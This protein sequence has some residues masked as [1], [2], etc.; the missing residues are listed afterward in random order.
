MADKRWEN[1]FWEDLDDPEY[2]PAESGRIDWTVQGVRGTRQNPNRETILRSPPQLIGGYHWRIKLYPRGDDTNQLSA[3]VECSPEAWSDCDETEDTS[4]GEDAKMSLETSVEG[5][6]A[7]THAPEQPSR[8]ASPAAEVSAENAD[9]P[10]AKEQA[11]WG[12]AAQFGVV[13]YNPA[14]PR[15]LYAFKEQY[16]FCNGHD[17]FGRKRF[18]GPWD[19]IHTR[20]RGQRQALLRNDTLALSAYIRIVKDPTGSLW[21]SSR[22]EGPGWDNLARTGLRGISSK[23]DGGLIFRAGMAAWIYLPPFQ[24]LVFGLEVPNQ[25]KE[26]RTRPKPLWDALQRVVYVAQH[27]SAPINVV[28]L[29]PVMEA[30]RWYGISLKAKTDTREAWE[31][32]KRKMEHEARGTE[33]ETSLAELFGR[34]DDLPEPTAESQSDGVEVRPQP[35]GDYPIIRLPVERGRSVGEL[36]RRELEAGKPVPSSIVRSAP[37]LL[38]IELERQVFDDKKR[39]WRKVTDRVKLDDRL[40]V[41]GDSIDKSEGHSYS[42]YGM[43]VHT[44]ALQSDRYYP[45]IRPGGPGTKWF[46]FFG[47]RKGYRVQCITTKQAVSAHEGI[48]EGKTDDETAAVAYLAMY[49]RDDVFQEENGKERR[50]ERASRWGRGMLLP[51]SSVLR[52]IRFGSSDTDG[53]CSHARTR[54]KA[55]RAV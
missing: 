55:Y 33:I 6:E 31:T 40:V 9:A 1:T 42:L 25:E 28:D 50:D 29:A 41:G 2:L 20:Q 11:P 15:V 10:K 44:G 54:P 18:H 21:W 23:V 39:R 8:P 16:Q 45:V 17:N 36:L 27:P 30:L 48:D 51:D 35:N 53:V 32:V 5:G 52:R 22:D 7:K 3:Y 24:D 43:I 49:V 38:Q 19:E 34:V 26:P 46:K 14:E 13:L 12:V 4:E 47:E 37:K